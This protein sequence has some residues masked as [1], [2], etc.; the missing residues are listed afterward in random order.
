[1]GLAAERWRHLVLAAF[2]GD[3]AAAAHSYRS[4]PN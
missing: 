1:M 4:K 2:E 3:T